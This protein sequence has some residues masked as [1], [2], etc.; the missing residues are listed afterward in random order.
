MALAC[1]RSREGRAGRRSGGGWPPRRREGMLCVSVCVL[2]LCLLCACVGVG[3]LKSRAGTRAHASA[4]RA[5]R[6]HAHSRL[7]TRGWHAWVFLHLHGAGRVPEQPRWLP[8]LRQPP[9]F[10]ATLISSCPALCAP[11]LPRVRP[12]PACASWLLGACPPQPTVGRRNMQ[13]QLRISQQ[14]TTVYACHRGRVKVRASPR[15]SASHT[16]RPLPRARPASHVPCAV[17]IPA[18]DC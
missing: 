18:V 8:P 9:A 7:R 12:L 10:T 17:L 13:R 6:R 11:V 16:H 3:R 15:T 14:R 5:A 2:S 1:Q 4:S